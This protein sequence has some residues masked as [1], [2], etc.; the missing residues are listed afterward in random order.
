MRSTLEPLAAVLAALAVAVAP[1]VLSAQSP[2]REITGLEFEGNRAFP[3]D[4]LA[5]AI[6]TAETSCKTVVLAPFCW[7]TDWGFAKDREYLDESTLP[8][9]LLRLRLFYRRRGYR[10][11]RVDTAV[12]RLNGSA[13]VAFRIEEGQPT[14]LDSLAFRGLE[15]IV[16]TAAVREAFPLQPGE[17]FDLIA[18]NRAK[19][20]IADRLR[21]VGYAGAEV[22]DE[23]F[24]P[25]GSRRVQLT[26]EARPGPLTRIGSVTV[27]G[28]EELGEQVV[29]RFLDVRSGQVYRQDRILE[30]Q[31]SLYRLPAIRF[32]NIRTETDTAVDSLE[33]VTVD[34]TPAAPRS[35]RAGVGATTT[36]CFQG[37]TSFTHRNFLGGARTLELTGR[38]SNLLA[39]DLAGSFPCS[40]VGEDPVFQDVGFTVRADFEQS[41]FFSGRNSLQASLFLER[42]TVPDLFVRSSRGGQLG[43]TRR[44]RSRMPLTLSYRPELTSFD[45][46]SADVFFCVN[47]G[48]CQ[49]EDIDALTRARWLV[50]LGLSWSYDRTNA[51]FS[52]TAGYYSN[53]SLE[54]ADDLTGSDYQYVRFNLDVA[55]FEE[56]L[57]GLVL[58]VRMRAGFVEALG[59]Q[60][61]EDPAGGGESVIH[62]R[63]RFFVGGAQSVRGFGQN[64]LGPSVLVMDVARCTGL[65]FGTSRPELAAC[66]RQ[67]ASRAT[68]PDDFFDER[69]VGGNAAFEANVELRTRLNSTWSVVGFADF[70]QVWES[71]GRIRAPVTTPGLGIRYSSPVGPL[72]LDLAYDPTAPERVPVVAEF[73]QTGD[74]LGELLELEE[75]VRFDTYTYDAPGSFREFVR[76]LKLHISIGEAF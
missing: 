46:E 19:E 34:V 48:F 47:F 40:D 20:A 12:T 36:D 75:S 60:A 18:L 24:I 67:L 76:R 56:L 17:P 27:Q 41:Y 35:V 6:I 74:R 70:G 7:I 8:A 64:L 32:A 22:L 15:G 30:S 55:D 23:Y 49:P 58:A 51:T 61:F 2:D 42:E 29:R 14:V 66:A 57:P 31:R 3:D 9:D 65:G 62:P 54:W 38:L 28:A 71:L 73:T 53:L 11:V 43:V 68:N 59:D 25:A 26:V 37:E 13:R 33:N 1:A 16:D 5:E 4:R 63:K 21:N 10:A 72:R 44:L 39:R 45:E 69:P 50:P 52:P